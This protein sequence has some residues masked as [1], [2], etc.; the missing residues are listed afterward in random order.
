[1]KNPPVNLTDKKD[2]ELAA[3]KSLIRGESIHKAMA[4]SGIKKQDIFD[5]V[6]FSPVALQY[7]HEKIRGKIVLQG[8]PAAYNFMFKAMQDPRVDMRIR[9][10]CAEFFLNSGG[11]GAPKTQEMPFLEAK[12][13]Q[14]REV[15]AKELDA[16]LE[17]IKRMKAEREAAGQII[18]VTPQPIAQEDN[19]RSPASQPI[20]DMF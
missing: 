2:K 8:T 4:I 9:M 19:T 15:S 18:D 1:M 12:D 10:R 16:L 11:Q 5:S 14:A 17:Q 13:K 6:F 7:C 20:E 3:V